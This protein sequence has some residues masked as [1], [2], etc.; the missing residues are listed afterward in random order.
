M[1]KFKIAVCQNKPVKN[2]DE[3]VAQII[4]KIEEAKANARK[5]LVQMIQVNVN[6][7]SLNI[8]EINNFK[9][10]HSVKQKIEQSTNIELNSKNYTLY[11]QEKLD[12][13]W[14]VGFILTNSI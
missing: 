3:S 1:K 9:K 2:K 5:D 4:T 7:V 12:G 6:T 13:R 14:Y 11:K 8:K 10:F